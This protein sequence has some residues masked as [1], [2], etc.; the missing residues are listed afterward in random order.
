MF[1]LNQYRSVE[2]SQIQFWEIGAVQNYNSVLEMYCIK[3]MTQSD[4]G[5]EFRFS[6]AEFT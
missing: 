3:F 1:L 6:A 5:D 2:E 4:S